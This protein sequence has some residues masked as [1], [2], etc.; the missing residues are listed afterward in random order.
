MK[1]NARKM[2]RIAVISA[3]LCVISPFTIPIGPIPLSLATLGVYIASAILEPISA[4]VSVGI[5]ILLGAFGL[6]VFSGVRGGFSVI[7]GPTGGY[8][9][10]YIICAAAASYLLHKFPKKALAP[11]WYVIS[12]AVLYLFGTL[13]YMAVTETHFSAAVSVCVVPFLAGDAI[14]IAAAMLFSSKLSRIAQRF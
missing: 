12:T 7:A 6:P 8:I 13:W 2:T 3:V 1:I 4:T 5:Y 9:I 11:I 10:G 14:K